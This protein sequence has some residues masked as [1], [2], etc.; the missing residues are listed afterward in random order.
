L[1]DLEAGTPVDEVN[2]CSYG[3]AVYWLAVRAKP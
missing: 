3:V 1:V 2:L